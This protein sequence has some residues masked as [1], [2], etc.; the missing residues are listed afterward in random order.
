[1]H[2]SADPTIDSQSQPISSPHHA[3]TFI[4]TK[5]TV[6]RP[7]LYGSC[8]ISTSSNAPPLGVARIQQLSCPCRCDQTSHLSTRLSAAHGE[9][10]A[11]L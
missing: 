8:H 11:R 1:M 10:D 4:G 5:N 2:H 3:V 7:R 6:H 9:D